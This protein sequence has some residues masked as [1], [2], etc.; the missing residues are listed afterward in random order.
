MDTNLPTSTPT[1]S[2]KSSKNKKNTVLILSIVLGI[3]FIIPILVGIAYIIFTL[4][5]TPRIVKNQVTVINPLFQ[6]YSTQID[7][8]AE[9]IMSDSPSDISIE[10]MERSLEKDKST[11]T[12]AIKAK[13]NLQ[14]ALKQSNSVEL[15][16]YNALVNDYVKKTE[17][18]LNV[19][20]ESNDYGDKWIP[21][22]REYE[23]ITQDA[24][25]ISTYIYSN[26]EKYITEVKKIVQAEK[27]L[28]QKIRKIKPS[29]RLSPT[30]E[31]YLKNF[32]AEIDFLEKVQMDVYN[33]DT[34]ALQDDIAQ[35]SIDAKDLQSKLSATVDKIQDDVQIDY[36]K[37]KTLK[38]NIDSEYT[39]L[40]SKFKF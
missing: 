27:D 24:S 37:A 17:I 39:Y 20:R 30:H 22:Q 34:K 12:L 11:Y 23:K 5:N 29:Q 19:A 7:K 38:Q 36:D 6:E 31:E 25:T 9:S 13:E 26:P 15:T 2:N 10:T 33:R 40:R 8:L 18:V 1:S 16:K 3:L 21:L 35:Y 4:I 14:N 28:I 32:Q